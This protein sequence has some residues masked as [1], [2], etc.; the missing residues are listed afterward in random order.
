M[1]TPSRNISI[2]ESLLLWKGCL[3]FKQY[4]PIKRARFGVKCFILCKDSGYTF[5][6]KIYTGRENVPP[7][8]GALSVSERIVADLI[9]PLLDRGYHLYIDNWYTSRSL[10]EFL[11]DHSTLACGTKLK[12]GEGAKFP[13]ASFLTI[14][15]CRP[16]LSP[17]MMRL[18]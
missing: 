7:P 3:G 17:L 4:I 6:F 8:A 2:E 1:Y 5:K 11:F 12:R 9:E 16:L 13:P 15:E 10:T 18:N 14:F